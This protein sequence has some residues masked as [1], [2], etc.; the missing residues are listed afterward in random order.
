V[1]GCYAA[2]CESAGIFVSS[3]GA[4]YVTIENNSVLGGYGA[5][6]KLSG[7]TDD[8]HPS[9][10]TISRNTIDRTNDDGIQIES[11]TDLSGCRIL[12]NTGIATDVAGSDRFVS[13]ESGVTLTDFLV[14]GNRA[15]STNSVVYFGNSS[16][17]SAKVIDNRLIS[18]VGSS[19]G[20][21]KGVSPGTDAGNVSY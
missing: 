12:D 9:Q 18:S 5:G 11:G 2:R 1:S 17:T 19:P 16:A 10:V 3:Q 14:A 8:G 6:I 20:V 21:I 4:A 7:T 15:L 13:V